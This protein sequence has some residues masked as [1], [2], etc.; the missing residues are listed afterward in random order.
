MPCKLLNSNFLTYYKYVHHDLYWHEH[1]VITKLKLTIFTSRFHHWIQHE[2]LHKI[3]VSHD[4]FSSLSK[5]PVWPPILEHFWIH[6]HLI[7]YHPYCL[8]HR[9]GL[10]ICKLDEMA[11]L[12]AIVSM[13]WPLK[14]GFFQPFWH[15]NPQY[16][17]DDW[18]FLLLDFT[19]GIGTKTYLKMM[20]HM[21]P[22]PPL[23][24]IQDGGQNWRISDFIAIW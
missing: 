13:L 9:N 14:L 20:C 17:G 6:C 16:F 23:K 12:S 5:N 21:T 18:R 10:P 1:P 19:I 3:D 15:E 2:K 4:H 22:F 8:W 7:A 11:C 24:K